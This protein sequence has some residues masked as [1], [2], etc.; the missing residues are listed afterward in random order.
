MTTLK[1]LRAVALAFVAAMALVVCPVGTGT[2]DAHLNDFHWHQAG[3]TVSQFSN[4][5]TNMTGLV[6]TLVNSNACWLTVDGSY[7]A[8]TTWAVAH[9][10]NQML[11]H[12]NGGVMDSSMWFAIEV[13]TD[14]NNQFRRGY[15]GVTDG[16]GTQWHSYYGGF[17]SN[18]AL[19]W[20]PFA[21]IWLFSQHPN[22]NPGLLVQATTARTIS[23]VAGCP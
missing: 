14:P 23:P 18:A 10:Q 12:N 9:F 8:A 19:G 2:A 15:A 22:S 3:H 20:N 1:P 16:F 7:G 4:K 13:A 17:P 5:N 21:S 11:G 6:Q